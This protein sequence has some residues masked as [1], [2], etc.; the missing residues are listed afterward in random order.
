MHCIQS[1][2]DSYLLRYDTAPSIGKERN[3][4]CIRSD[5]LGVLG[6]GLTVLLV[7]EEVVAF[8]VIQRFNDNKLI[9]I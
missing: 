4:S 3:I 7:L 8:S 5:G 9:C 2:I 1:I 6:D